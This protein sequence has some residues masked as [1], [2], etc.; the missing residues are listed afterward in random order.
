MPI[1]FFAEDVD[2]QTDSEQ[3]TADWL[4][5]IIRQELR[6]P[7]ELNIIF[8][9]DAHLHQIN[10]TYLSHDTY[11]DIITFDHSET[12]ETITGDVFI[13]IDRVKEN[14]SRLAVDFDNELHR[15]IIHGVLHLIGYK[16]KSLE[17]KAQMR[18]KEDAC[19]SL[20]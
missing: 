16:D 12:V 4:N 11:T 5:K 13:S 8:C 2:F 10:L 14:A 6:K 9:S 15:V 19:L 7:G 17:E 1:H 20:R 3:Q 18:E